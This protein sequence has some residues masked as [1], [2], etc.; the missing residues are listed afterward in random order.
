MDKKETKLEDL[1]QE[2]KEYIDHLELTNDTLDL[3]VKLQH[4]VIK[5]AVNNFLYI[6]KIADNYRVLGKQVSMEDVFRA[7]DDMA[8]KWRYYPEFIEE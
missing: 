7:I 4:E 8:D 3:C 1:M 2:L 5:E 6:E